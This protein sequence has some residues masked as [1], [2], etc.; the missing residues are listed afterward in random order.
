MT[1]KTQTTGRRTITGKWSAECSIC[2]NPVY[3]LWIDDNDDPGGACIE[4]ATVITDCR[5]AMGRA[6]LSAD[7]VKMRANGELL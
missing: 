7:I 6:R 1:E 2:R 5:D 3:A 4:G